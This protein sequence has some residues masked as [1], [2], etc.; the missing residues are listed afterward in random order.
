MRN[1]QY[2]RRPGFTLIEVLVITGLVFIAVSLATP[3]IQRAR[4]QSRATTCQNN[5]KMIGLALHN[6]HDTYF[7]LPAAW[8]ARF[9]Q[10]DSPSWMGWQTS[11]LPFTEQAPLYQAIYDRGQGRSVPEWPANPSLAQTAIPGYL[12][13]MD[14]TGPQNPFRGGFGASSY[15]GNFGPD[16]LP[17]WYESSAELFWPGAIAAPT[18]TNGIFCV[19]SNTNFRDITDGLSNTAIVSERAARSGAGLWIGVRSNRGDNDA[20][21]DMNFLSGINKSYAGF[22]SRHEGAVTILICDGSVRLILDTID[23]KADS[24]GTLQRLSDRRDGQVIGEF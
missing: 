5:L 20:I 24:T 2:S 19:N 17:R 10:A 13:P 6:Y 8:Y 15:S 18:S 21:T 1:V 3:A 11:L 14:T 12:C 9:P 16:L 22:S 4:Q 23:S 7:S